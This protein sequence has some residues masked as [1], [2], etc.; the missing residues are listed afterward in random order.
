MLPV[1]PEKLFERVRLRLQYMREESELG[2]ESSS[3]DLGSDQL[4]T[5]AVDLTREHGV[6]PEMWMKFLSLAFARGGRDER[7]VGL[8]GLDQGAKELD[9]LFGERM[10]GW[11][12]EL[13]GEEITDALARPAGWWVLADL[14]RIGYL[15]SWAVRGENE[16]K[17][18]LGALATRELNRDGQNHPH[19]SFLVLRHL[20]QDS[21][22]HVQRAV[23]E[24]IAE[25][26]PGDVLE[27]FL[28]WWA[29]RVEAEFLKTITEPLDRE[30]QSKILALR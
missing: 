2:S 12:R 11:A 30:Q 22:P 15:E 19:Q 1:T 7:L 20:M 10:S 13:S 23:A 5:L 29:P 9:D 8:L 21:N 28:A 24:A 16:W 25:I 17:R 4:K 3:K 18:A 27:R 14:S 26:Q 6:D